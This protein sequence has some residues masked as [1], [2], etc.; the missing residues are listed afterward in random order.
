MKQTV[1]SMTG[2][3]RSFGELRAVN[4]VDLTLGRGEIYGLV[5]PDGA[6]KTTL[7]RLLAGALAPDS[8]SIRVMGLDV[9]NEPDR[10]RERVGYM[11]QL[12]GL[13]ADLTV[14]E[15]LRF[16]AMLF[17]VKKRREERIEELLEFVRLTEF[18]NRRAD[19]LSGGMYKKLAIACSI[20]HRP[21][22]LLLDE[23]T[24]GVDP[25]SRRDLWALLFSLAADGVAVLVSTPYMD[26][27]ERC[28]RVGLMYDGM[29]VREGTPD[30]LLE[31]LSN[32]VY[33][34]ESE[35][36]ASDLERV[37]KRLPE[38]AL[39]A[40]APGGIRV[41]LTESGRPRMRMKAVQAGIEDLLMLVQYRKEQE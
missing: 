25:V 16:F 14:Y 37:Q 31:E 26:E 5:G 29:L 40:V 32:R 9:A 7:M 8:G 17:G 11:P 23:P 13:Y 39:S 3:S 1:I 19:N 15:N 41:I 20:L 33:L 36:P 2:V 10:I 30:H 27:A 12:F 18:R 22:L 28:H 6:G 24:N 4:G 34:I 21:D 35:N 38:G